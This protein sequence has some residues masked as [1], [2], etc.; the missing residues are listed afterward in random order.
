MRI[1]LVYIILAIFSLPGFQLLIFPTS[2]TLE[3]ASQ[4]NGC[5]IQKQCH[6][7]FMDQCVIIKLCFQIILKLTQ[8][9]FT[10]MTIYLTGLLTKHG[11]SILYVCIYMYL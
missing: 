3:E 6:C 9:I 1:G 7:I 10:S 4:R 8:V 2:T 11:H 5:N